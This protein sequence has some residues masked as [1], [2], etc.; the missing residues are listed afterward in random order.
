VSNA[1]ASPASIAGT[2]FGNCAGSTSTFSC[3][4]VSGATVYTWTVPANA[5]INSG[6]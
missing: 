4:S 6:Q 1:T 2:L 5:I 3:P